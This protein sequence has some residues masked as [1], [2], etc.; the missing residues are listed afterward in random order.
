MEYTHLLRWLLVLQ[1]CSYL[2]LG[3]AANNHYRGCAGSQ[4]ACANQGPKDQAGVSTG[5]GKAC[6]RVGERSAPGV[7][8]GVGQG[9]SHRDS[10]GT[11]DDAGLSSFSGQAVG[12]CFADGDREGEGALGVGGCAKFLRC[13]EN[14]D[15]GGEGGTASDV[16]ATCCRRLAGR[17]ADDERFAGKEALAAEHEA[18][19]RAN[20]AVRNSGLRRESRVFGCYGR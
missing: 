6:T 7:A 12:A 15:L 14:G 5:V 1:L 3:A 10:D 16:G 17:H 4:C 9:S 8:T 13:Q 2:S 11:N 20:Y 19:A 18:F